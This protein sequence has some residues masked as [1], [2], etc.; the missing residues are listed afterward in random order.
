MVVSARGAEMLTKC[1]GSCLARGSVASDGSL[2]LDPW[3]VASDGSLELAPGAS[4]AMP[5]ASTARGDTDGVSGDGS[6]AKRTPSA[7]FFVC[8]LVIPVVGFRRHFKKVPTLAWTHSYALTSLR[9]FQESGNSFV[10]DNSR[11]WPSM[12]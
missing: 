4:S 7:R 9:F 10:F 12:V 5:L 2:E 8:C 1:R 11:R 6:Y 3:S